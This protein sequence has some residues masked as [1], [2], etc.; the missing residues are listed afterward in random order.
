M[1]LPFNKFC[2]DC[3]RERS[4]HFVVTLGVYVC[5]DCSNKLIFAAGGNSN[6]LI[7]RIFN[8]QWDNYHLKSVA[9]GGNEKFFHYLREY[10]AERKTLA[11]NYNKDFLKYFR[12]MHL[13]KIEGDSHN[14]SNVKKPPKDIGGKISQT[15]TKVVK[16]AATGAVTGVK[17]VGKGGM[18]LLKKIKSGGVAVGK[19]A[20]FFGGKVATGSK[21]VVTN[22]PGSIKYAAKGVAN[23]SVGAAKFVGSGVIGVTHGVKNKIQRKKDPNVWNAFYDIDHEILPD[24]VKTELNSESLIFII[25]V[26]RMSQSPNDAINALN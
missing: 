1:I 8:E 23:K 20:K 7:K 19:G 5:E 24:N 21:A 25:D 14:F 17:G 9:Y 2:V 3:K 22:A 15:S 26:A 10:G 12:M 16:G 18:F 13:A 6:C 11:E 4:T